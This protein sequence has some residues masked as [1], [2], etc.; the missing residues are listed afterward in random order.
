[1]LEKEEQRD[2]PRGEWDAD[3]PAADR[4]TPPAAGEARRRN[5]QRREDELERERGV[6][7][8]YAIPSSVTIT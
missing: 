6:D 7:D 2:R 5:E 3:E 1:V 8:A 4:V